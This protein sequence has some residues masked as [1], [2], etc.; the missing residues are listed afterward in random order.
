MVRTTWGLQLLTPDLNCYIVRTSCRHEKFAREQPR[1]LAIADGFAVAHRD[2]PTSSERVQHVHTREGGPVRQ[3][4]FG[5]PALARTHNI[6]L[7]V[8][9]L[10]SMP[11]HSSQPSA[12]HCR[13]MCWTPTLLHLKC[14]AKPDEVRRRTR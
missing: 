1:A 4:A 5:C 8:A 12:P 3:E 2:R 7:N 13:H 10:Q 14:T 11:L 6:L 9:P